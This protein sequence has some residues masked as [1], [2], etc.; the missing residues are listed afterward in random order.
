MV[1]AVYYK[2][3]S[4]SAALQS[5]LIADWQRQKVWIWRHLYAFSLRALLCQEL[6]IRSDCNYNKFRLL[7][8]FH[9]PS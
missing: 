3:A 7:F 6:L 2:Y 1:D 9:Q 5:T 8:H 4:V